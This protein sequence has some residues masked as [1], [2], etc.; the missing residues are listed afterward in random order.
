MEKTKD[1]AYA[2]VAFIQERKM[3]RN[4]CCFFSPTRMHLLKTYPKVNAQ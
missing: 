2:A 1:I 4:P 3:P